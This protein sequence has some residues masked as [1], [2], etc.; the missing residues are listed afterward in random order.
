MNNVYYEVQLDF[1]EPSKQFKDLEDV[2]SFLK[3]NGYIHVYTSSDKEYLAKVTEEEVDAIKYP[4]Y[5]E[6]DITSG[7]GMFVESVD[8]WI[9]EHML[10]YF[11]N[12]EHR[13]YIETFL[14]NPIF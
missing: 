11:Y 2:F 4:V 13:P 1:D 6:P 14:E 5:I 3:D 9:E 7:D 8:F 10:S 12:L